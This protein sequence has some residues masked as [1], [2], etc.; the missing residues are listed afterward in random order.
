[1]I[2]CVCVCDRQVTRLIVE[3]LLLTRIAYDDILRM[4]IER[5][6]GINKIIDRI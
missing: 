4:K 5:T 3:L 1:M 6:S 2:L